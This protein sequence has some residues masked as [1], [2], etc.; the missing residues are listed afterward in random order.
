ML[1]K[2]IQYMEYE[3]ILLNQLVKYAEL[4]QESLRAFDV[5]SIEQYSEFQDKVSVKLKLAE[6]ERIDMIMS[7]MGLTKTE[8]MSLK[9]STIESKLKGN[10]FKIV[11]N[12]RTK[13]SE[14]TEKLNSLNNNNRILINRTKNSVQNMMDIFTNGRN[15]FNVKV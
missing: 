1:S 8:A 4:Q 2:L 6:K 10:N 12:L 3:K 13:L 15:I 14:L 11:S 5:K 9:L 7:W